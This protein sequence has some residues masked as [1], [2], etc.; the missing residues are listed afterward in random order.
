MSTQPH[1][2]TLTLTLTYTRATGGPVPVTVA[3]ALSHLTTRWAASFHRSRRLAFLLLKSSHSVS[4]SL[5]FH[6]D[7]EGFFSFSI[8]LVG[9]FFFLIF[10][11]LAVLGLRCCA[12][13]SSTCGEQGLLFVVVHGLLI[14]VAP[15]VAEHGL[16]ARGLQ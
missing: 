11:F 13:A 14:A 8:S 9:F 4:L 15:L 2:H 10:L 12:R 6:S 16:Q 1:A 5:T 3:P 7:W